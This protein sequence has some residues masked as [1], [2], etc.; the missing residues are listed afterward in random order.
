L[1]IGGA[2]NDMGSFRVLGYRVDA[3]GKRR[4]RTG[5]SWVFAVDFGDTPTAYSVVAY[6]QSGRENSPHFADQAALFANDEMKKVSF[7]EAEI[8][9]S[10][11][12]QY[13]PGEE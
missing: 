2:G 13:H 6:S 8:A 5:D 1:P 10:L 11:I 3:D 7:T 9:S 4:A 12:S